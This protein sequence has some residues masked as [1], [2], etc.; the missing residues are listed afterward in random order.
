VALRQLYGK[1]RQ[2][3]LIGTVDL[4]RSHIDS[5]SGVIMV[6]FQAELITRLVE[7]SVQSSARA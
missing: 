5:L 3:G 7:S 2:F 6:F 1:I 4:R